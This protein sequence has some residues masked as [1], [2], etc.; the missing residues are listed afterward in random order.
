M[1]IIVVNTAGTVLA[2]YCT[3]TSLAYCCDYGLYS[4]D[5]VTI[6]N[7]STNASEG[8][9]D[10]SC[11]HQTT[12]TEGDNHLIS[13]GTGSINAQDTRVWID[14]NNDGDLDASELVFEALNEFDPS[15]LISIPSG[16]VF[17]TP[18]R[19]RIISDVIGNVVGSCD[20]QNFGQ[21][22]DYGI[23]IEPISVPPVAFFTSNIQ[24]TC[25][26]IVQFSD[27]STNAPSQ[28]LWD[29]GDLSTSMDQNPLHTYTTPGIYTVSLTATNLNGSDDFIANNYIEYMVGPLC[30]TILLPTNGPGDTYT[31]CEGVVMDDGGYDDYSPGANGW[32]TISPTG[33]ET[34]TLF[35][36][37][38]QYEPNTDFLILY[39]G[40]NITSPIIG[41]FSGFGVN[42][43]PNNGVIT[44][45][46]P[47][48]T[49]Q[50]Q[51]SFGFLNFEGFLANWECSYLGIDENV[52]KEVEIFPNPT[53]DQVTIDLSGSDHFG[54]ALT[55][56]NIV[57]KNVLTDQIP[58]NSTRHHV[59][60]GH[61]EP[62]VYLITLEMESVKMTKKIILN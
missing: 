47:S 18:L 57:G 39:D 10:F 38:F 22:E 46:G 36:Q 51:T 30:D 11:Q 25:D 50:Q 9:Q 12:V 42:F 16:A 31:T 41:T 23:I 29:F 8:Y 61:L 28:W 44:S 45:S 1:D 7:S 53:E 14:L 34:V 62:G 40:P 3:P 5:L 24:T 43:L 33:A 15:G 21:T 19:M 37:E 54:V 55:I 17:N 35:F 20:D 2:A 13:I 59:Q 27:L 26:G 49:I 6:S 52:F 56:S 60:L 48:I 58:N 4:D 32:I